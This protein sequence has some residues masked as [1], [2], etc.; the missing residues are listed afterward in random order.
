VVSTYHLPLAAYCLLRIALPRSDTARLHQKAF[1]EGVFEGPMARTAQQ[2]WHDALRRMRLGAEKLKRGGQA[3]HLGSDSTR[4]LWLYLYNNGRSCLYRM[5]KGLLAGPQ[6]L[7]VSRMHRAEFV[8]QGHPREFAVRMATYFRDIGYPPEEGLWIVNW[9]A[10]KMQQRL[11]VDPKTNLFVGSVDFDSDL[12]FNSYADWID[13]RK[14]KVA[15]GYILPFLVCPSDSALPS[16]VR[17]AA[18]IPT[19]LTY[20][21]DTLHRYLR[22]IGQNLRGEGFCHLIVNGADNA[23]VHGTEMTRR[24]LPT[25]YADERE[26]GLTLGDE[27]GAIVTL[28]GFH[29]RG[30]ACATVQVLDPAHGAKNGSLQPYS[31]SRLLLLGVWPVL[32]MQLVALQREVRASGLYAEDAN[33]SDRMSVSGAM[34]RLNFAVRRELRQRAGT[35]GAIAYYYFMACT[36]SAYFDRNP[37]TTPRARAQRAMLNLIFL[38]YWHGWIEATGSAAHHFISIQT[39]RAYIVKDSAL[40]LLVL[41]FGSKFRDKPFTPWLWG[42]NQL[43]H[44]FSEWRSFEQG[45][46]T[47]TLLSVLNI[48]KRWLHQTALFASA[49]VELPAPDSNHG[50]SR[51]RFRPEQSQPHV[52]EDYPTAEELLIMYA[53]AVKFVKQVLAAL[54]MAQALHDAGLWDEPPLESWEH[55]QDAAESPAERAA[56]RADDLQFEGLAQQHELAAEAAEAAELAGEDEEAQEEAAAAAAAAE[57]AAAEAAMGRRRRRRAQ[58]SWDAGGRYAV[59]ELMKHANKGSTVGLADGQT[60]IQ[61]RHFWVRWAGEQWR[62]EQYW[63]WEAQSELLPDIPELIGEYCR[64]KKLVVP[65]EAREQ[66][67][68]ALQQAEAEAEEE[69]REAPQPAAHGR[70]E[71]QTSIPDYD[72]EALFDI[73]TAPIGDEAANGSYQKVQLSTSATAAERRAF[74]AAHLWNE[75]TGEWEPKQTLMTLEQRQERRSPPPPS[76]LLLPAPPPSPPTTRTPT[77]I[78]GRRRQGGAWAATLQVWHSLCDRFRGRGDKDG[79]LVWRRLPVPLRWQ[80][81]ARAVDKVGALAA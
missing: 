64:R 38:R 79:L 52:Q 69:A 68:A 21:A 11:Q 58:P 23:A 80:H 43:E 78:A 8:A 24:A 81:W 75:E 15:A 32:H 65:V 49:D 54:G 17:V 73:M 57:V 41:L 18:L 42:S 35:F 66:V 44:M 77:A 13:F 30:A 33:G 67:A 3:A 6:R 14:N 60:K 40:L 20:D 10:A 53:E 28:R 39:F 46:A 62:A 45:N 56:A 34:R 22:E 19:D 76:L 12:A 61:E 71:S 26:P 16:V 74:Q 4:A 50:Y 27:I 63:T 37:K 48:C 7:A 36:I 59:A 51:T 2:L 25:H 72:V 70:P 55:L 31:L 47:W 29:E 5:F 1:E 9:D